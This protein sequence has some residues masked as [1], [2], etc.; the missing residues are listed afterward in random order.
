MTGPRQLIALARTCF[1][2]T[3]SQALVGVFCAA[4]LAWLAMD[5]VTAVGSIAYIRLCL[6]PAVAGAWIGACAGRVAR[7]HGSRFAPTFGPTFGLVSALASVLALGLTG[8]VAWIGG[9]DARPVVGLGTL[10]MTAGLVTG[11]A[12]PRSL[13]YVFLALAIVVAYTAL[14]D[15]PISVP[16]VPIGGA[17]A[18]VVAF[19]IATSLIVRFTFRVGGTGP[20]LR[21]YRPQRQPWFTAL[22]GHRF[23]EP[24]MGRIAV[25]S[26]LLATG[27]S[28]A[29]RLPTFEWRDGPLIIVI[30]SVCANLGVT[31]TSASLA[32]GPI[33]GT[34]WLLLS[35]IAKT[36]SDAGRKILWGVVANSAFA[37]GVFIAL[38][39]VWGPDWDLVEMMLVALAAC[40]AYLAAACHSRWLLSSRLSVLVATPTVVALSAAAWAYGPWGLTSSIAACLL[41]GIAAVYLGGVGM[42]RVDLDPRPL[43][44]KS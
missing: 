30:G 10:S 13:T 26:G 35:G 17:F 14:L 19:T 33:P 27:C 41:T 1:R 34:A 31:S 44:A 20:R 23:S 21:P 16:S 3:S 22:Q 38:S 15:I 43:D 9:L 6:I 39:L 25:W 11:C 12:Q 32:R 4:Y 7:W 40:H 2:P 42:A 29:H 37:A 8:L 36:R 5:G 24:S 18:M 28:F